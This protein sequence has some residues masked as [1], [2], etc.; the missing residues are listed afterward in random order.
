MSTSWGYVCQ[1]HNPPLESDLWISRGRAVLTDLY[2]KDR[3]G[4]WPDIPE[5]HPHYLAYGPDTPMAVWP[6]GDVAV[7]VAPRAGGGAPPF[8]GPPAWLREH[9]HCIVALHNVYGDVISLDQPP[10]AAEGRCVHRPRHAVAVMAHTLPF[11]R[12]QTL[13]PIKS[14]QDVLAFDSRDW[15]E[16]RGDAWLYGI[17]FGWDADPDDPEDEGAMDS[18]AAKHGWDEATVARLRLLHE[19]FKATLPVSE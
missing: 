2:R 10:A 14:I 7:P 19:R 13:H 12:A 6:E 4:E 18:V 11:A 1:S 16:D 8:K 9:P 17:V 15:G 3:A 5:G